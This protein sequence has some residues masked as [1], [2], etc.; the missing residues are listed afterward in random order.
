MELTLL[1]WGKV[2]IRLIPLN[3]FV[4]NDINACSGNIG[5]TILLYV[6]IPFYFSRSDFF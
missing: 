3:V 6:S 2:F 1:F 4:L 5:H